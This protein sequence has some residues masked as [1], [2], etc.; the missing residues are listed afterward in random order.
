MK[1]IKEQE[2]ES[3]LKGGWVNEVV[4]VGVGG[5]RRYRQKDLH[6]G[7]TASQIT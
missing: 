1:I 3:E 4:W 2:R 7:F 6:G 5:G